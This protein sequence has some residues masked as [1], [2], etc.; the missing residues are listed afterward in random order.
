MQNYHLQ[1]I[2]KLANTSLGP[3]KKSGLFVQ[4]ILVFQASSW[5]KTYKVQ[6]SNPDCLGKRRS[7]SRSAC[8]WCKSAARERQCCVCSLA[9]RHGFCQVWRRSIQALHTRNCQG[10]SMSMFKYLLG[11]VLQIYIYIHTYRYYIYTYI[12]YQWY[13]HSFQ[14]LKTQDSPLDNHWFQAIDLRI[15]SRRCQEAVVLVIVAVLVVVEV[16]RKPG[17]PA[18]YGSGCKLQQWLGSSHIVSLGRAAGCWG[19]A[20]HCDSAACTWWAQDWSLEFL[21][22][23]KKKTWKKSRKHQFY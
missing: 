2:W 23:K 15:R 11:G 6:L 19:R 17:G 1:A 21:S 18:T 3:K 16:P 8:D 5:N 10:G 13:L 22:K 4:C 12:L 9:R 20:W 14:S 7:W